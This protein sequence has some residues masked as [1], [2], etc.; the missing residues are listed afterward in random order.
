V[1]GTDDS[2]VGT[3]YAGRYD[4][5]RVLGEG[6]MGTVYAARHAFTGREVALKVLHPIV[7]RSRNARERFLREAQ[8]P[9][10]VGHPGIVQVLDAGVADDGT[11]Y[12]ALELLRGE[13]LAR[14]NERGGVD[15]ARLVSIVRALL[16][17]L[18]A[19]HRVGLVHRD[20]KPENVFLAR[21]PD[22]R[23]RVRLLDFGITRQ[24]TD[25]EGEKL[26]QTGTILG[27]PHYMSPEQ[28]Q[29]APVD[30]RSDLFSVGGVMF[31]ALTGR[32]P[33]AGA[34]YNLLI[35][36][37]MTTDAPAIRD[38]RP[39]VPADLASV[40]D[41]AL[42]RDPG[43]RFQSAEEMIAALDACAPLAL[44]APVA[45][46]ARADTYGAGTH[47][48][49]A[50]RIREDRVPGGQTTR[51]GPAATP[52][53]APPPRAASEDTARRTP[54]GVILIALGAAVV[55]A[56]A[57]VLLIVPNGEERTTT[58]TDGATPAEPAAPVALTPLATPGPSPDG[59][60][61]L[62]AGP[63]EAELAAAA[64]ASARAEA[65]RARERQRARELAKAQAA[66]AE[67]DRRACELECFQDQAACQ[68]E[69]GGMGLDAIRCHEAWNRC[70]RA[71][72]R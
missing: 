45:T 40:V 9:S 36:A 67:Q 24:V 52:P 43:A 57:A 68:R 3:R 21:E 16:D 25:T 13:D 1:E 10:S 26:T 19:A 61:P 14:A 20:I 29:G 7:A 6:G 27:T 46:Q 28:A 35:V 50:T 53:S 18:A 8:A 23:E 4:I 34:N 56:A 42:A 33:F 55:G 62:D 31:S 12:L 32:T 70:N 66:Q 58:T 64:E 41:R 5:E 54:W 48:T 63:S 37:I 71:C 44:P 11:L 47:P 65:A 2:L 30:A 17:T 49:P 60:A 15:G 72:R 69:T 59:G 22:G 39:D 38:V 51:P